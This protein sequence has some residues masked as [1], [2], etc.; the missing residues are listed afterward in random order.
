MKVGEDHKLSKYKTV[1]HLII[2]PKKAKAN[3]LWFWAEPKTDLVKNAKN[4]GSN[5][6]QSIVH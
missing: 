6:S 4:Q 5:L 1:T 2:F 3:T